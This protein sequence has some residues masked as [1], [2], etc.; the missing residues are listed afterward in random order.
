MGEISP[1]DLYAGL[2]AT[3][4]AL[5]DVREPWEFELC[6]IAGAI[7]VPLQ[8]LPDSLAELDQHAHLVIICHHGMRSHYAA[9]FLRDR[10]FSN[11]LNLA[12]G[13]DRWARDVDPS[14]PQY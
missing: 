13:V 12:G 6:R 5:V 7:N 8:R 10:G 9:E 3:P 11:V 4:Y 2:A 1:R 14:M